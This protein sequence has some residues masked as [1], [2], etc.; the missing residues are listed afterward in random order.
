[1]TAYLVVLEV[2]KKDAACLGLNFVNYFLGRLMFATIRRREM[3]DIVE[4]LVPKFH[5]TLG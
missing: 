1:M 5:I 3:G 2:R 4:K